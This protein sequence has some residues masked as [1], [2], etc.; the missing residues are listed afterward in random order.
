M[1]RPPCPILSREGNS[2]GQFVPQLQTPLAP[3]NVVGIHLFKTNMRFPIGPQEVSDKSARPTSG[4]VHFISLLKP[5][6][7]CKKCTHLISSL[8]LGT[9]TH[10]SW[11]CSN[12][13]QMMRGMKEAE[14]VLLRVLIPHSFPR[15]GIMENNNQD[16]FRTH[17]LHEAHKSLKR[18]RGHVF[19]SLAM[20][21]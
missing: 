7:W 8:S 13:L 4:F 19:Y 16:N 17:V 9:S 1:S 14:V 21:K 11:R 15:A 20:D 5:L 6:C 10:L 3:A 2:F 12:R 18:T